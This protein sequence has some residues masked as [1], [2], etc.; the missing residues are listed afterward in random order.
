MTASNAFGSDSETKTD[1]IEVS[2]F[3][4][5]VENYPFGLELIAKS[6]NV[7]QYHLL[8][9]SEPFQ[10]EIHDA[11]GKLVY[12]TTI[13]PSAGKTQFEID[14][15]KEASGYYLLHVSDSKNSKVQK[16]WAQ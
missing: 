12:Q 9:S 15:S 16:I 3:E 11:M 6:N 1:Y 7:F 5:I 14:L 10:V 2:H 13:N 8:G 4:G